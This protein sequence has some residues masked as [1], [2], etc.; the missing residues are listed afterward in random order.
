[1]AQDSLP[2]FND[3]LRDGVL[4]VVSKLNVDGVPVG[5]LLSF[6]IGLFWPTA[7]HSAETW[8]SIRKYAEAMVDKKIDAARID[9]LSKRL[10]GLKGIAGAY[11]DTSMGSPQKGEHLTNLLDDLTLFEGDFWDQDSPEQ[12][13]PLFSSFGTLWVFATAEQALCFKEVYQK[14]DVDAEKHMKAFRD[15]IAKYTA[16]AQAMFDRLYAW[17]FSLLDVHMEWTGTWG[18]DELW[19]FVD[20]YD[21]Y[22]GGPQSGPMTRATADLCA[23]Q[24]AAQINGGFVEDLQDLL[25]AAQLW[26]YADPSV[27]LPPKKEVVSGTG[28]IGSREGTEFLDRPAASSRVSHIRVRHGQGGV[29]N[30]LEVLYDGQSAGTHGDPGSGDLSELELAADE[31]VVEV[32]GRCGLFVDQ[33]YFTTDKGRTV[34]GG[35]DGGQAFSTKGHASWEDVSL[36]AM[37]GRSDDRRLTGLNPQWRHQTQMPPY[38]PT[39]KRTGTPVSSSAAVRLRTQEGAYVSDLVEEYS[40]KAAADEYFPKIGASPVSLQLRLAGGQPAADLTDHATVQVV[41]SEAT[42]KDYPVLGKFSSDDVYYYSDT[43]GTKQEWL[44]IKMIPSDGPLLTGEKFYLRN[45]DADWYLAPA[46]DGYVATRSEPYGWE[47]ELAT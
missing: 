35:G 2:P 28:P 12:M 10:D 11:R 25:A 1:M 26:A 5:G 22:D 42:A 32:S 40:G 14:D 37:G 15:G 6:V 47:V 24:R 9:T 17:R 27:K 4:D 13:F 45:L 3:T 30:C 36:F 23:A 19:T 29:V 16:G 33:L 21:G 44:L 7:D 31:K 43:E 41:T 46:G 34:G 38:V 8:E 18:T 20:N 39:Y